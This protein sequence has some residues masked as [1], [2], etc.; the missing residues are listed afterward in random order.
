MANWNDR[1]DEFRRQ[2]RDFDDEQDRSRGRGFD[3]HGNFGYEGEGYMSGGRPGR[4]AYEGGE[5]YEDLSRRPFNNDRGYGMSRDRGF[6]GYGRESFGGGTFREGSG[7][8]DYSE[9][10]GN[11]SGVGS[12]GVGRSNPGGGGWQSYGGNRGMSRDFGEGRNFDRGYGPDY[13]DRDD[14]S[15]RDSGG[16]G[17]SG[18]GPFGNSPYDHRSDFGGSLGRSDRDLGRYT[19]IGGST[20][21]NYDPETG[22]GSVT[23]D[24]EGFFGGGL[25]GI[26]TRRESYRGRGPK[27]YQRSDDRIRED[28]C[29]R[30]EQDHDIDASDIEVRVAAGVVTLSGSVTHRSMKRYAEDLVESIQGV[31]DVENQIRVSRDRGNEAGRTSSSGATTAGSSGDTGKS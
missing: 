14:F 21:S 22:R 25:S 17:R 27:G 8:S 10:S 20:A 31:K 30:L 19:N 15:P 6:S 11:F 23:G 13:G 3:P 7:L 16:G 24:G 28:V 4:S 5:G 9:A 1:D 29:D 26:D 18:A 2:D 12:A